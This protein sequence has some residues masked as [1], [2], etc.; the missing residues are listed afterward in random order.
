MAGVMV[1]LDDAHAERLRALIREKGEKDAARIVGVASKQTLFRAAAGITISHLTHTLICDRL[2][3]AP[4]SPAPARP[5]VE[6]PAVVPSTVAPP[7]TRE[8]G[9]NRAE[10][11]KPD[12]VA[13]W[14]TVTRAGDELAVFS[15]RCDADKAFKID[16]R[17]AAVVEV[18]SGAIVL[19]RPRKLG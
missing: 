9:G 16:V 15:R 6:V 8:R 17:A 5:V 10:P 12:G 19:E 4:P 11:A 14:R 3:V 18:A 1:T 2:G 13:R 7:K